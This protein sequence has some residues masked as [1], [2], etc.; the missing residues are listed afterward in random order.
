MSMCPNARAT[1]EE[2]IPPFHP[3][4]ST[5]SKATLKTF[6]YLQNPS[7]FLATRGSHYQRQDSRSLCHGETRSRNN[8]LMIARVLN[9]REQTKIPL[10][11][12]VL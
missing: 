2:G 10:T 7:P 8:S 12:V 9:I 3:N 1:C 6:H 11:Q 4:Q 5:V